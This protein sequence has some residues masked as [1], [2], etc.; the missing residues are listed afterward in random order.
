MGSS[1]EIRQ[2]FVPSFLILGFLNLFINSFLVHALRRL[3]KLQSLSFKLILCL[4][5]SD[6]ASGVEMLF[7][8]LSTIIF[9]RD[10]SS[11]SRVVFQ[12]TTIFF[13]NF[14]Q[15]MTIAVAVDRYVHMKYLCRYAEIITSHRIIIFLIFT[16]SLSLA[17]ASLFAFGNSNRFM[18]V[19][20]VILFANATIIFVFVSV[21]YLHAYRA[22]IRRI[23]NRNLNASNFKPES[24]H[25][26]PNH[27]FARA[28][29]CVL[30]SSLLCYAPYFVITTIKAYNDEH[31]VI[32]D[33]NHLFAIWLSSIIPVRFH[34]CFNSIFLILFDRTL[35]RYTLGLFQTR[36][37]STTQQ[38][39]RIVMQTL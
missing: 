39:L 22:I 30:I 8:E 32:I 7:E 26:N 9:I 17:F 33:R 12:A 19:P 2:K 25:R 1:N 14:S 38:A 24:A 23:G 16:F 21:T 34:S 13:T 10:E 28:I 31:K 29:L 11:I 5:I 18:F 6:I 35:R 4:T 36:H 3:N 20:R 27:D 15:L 37:N